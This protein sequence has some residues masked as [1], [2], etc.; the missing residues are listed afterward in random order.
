MNIHPALLPAFPG[1]DGYSDARLS[2]LT[3]TV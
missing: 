1:T 2:R 3:L